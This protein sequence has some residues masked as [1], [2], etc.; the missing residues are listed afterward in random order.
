M[1]RLLN[2]RWLPGIALAAGASTLLGAWANY[3]P[4]WECPLYGA[5]IMV[6]VLAIFLRNQD[7]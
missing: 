1:R 5:G 3:K 7:A 2:P 4:L 6:A